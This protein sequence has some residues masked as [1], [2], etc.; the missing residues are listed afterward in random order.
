MK[1]MLLEACVVNL[2]DDRG[3]QHFVQG[4]E[5][6]VPKD[7]AVSLVRMGRAKFMSKED[8]FDKSGANTMSKEE[9]AKLAPAV[10][11]KKAA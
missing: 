10:T 1:V 8:D 4:A 7:E 11:G 3:G 5:V 2:R 6:D 9:M